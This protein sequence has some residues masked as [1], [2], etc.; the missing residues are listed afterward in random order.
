MENQPDTGMP[1]QDNVSVNGLNVQGDMV[2]TVGVILLAIVGLCLVLVLRQQIAFNR[3]ML[4]AL[5]K[6]ID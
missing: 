3:E 1:K 2:D 6:K 4:R 5:M